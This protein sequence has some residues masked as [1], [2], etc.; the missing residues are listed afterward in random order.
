[1]LTEH[2]LHLVI[3]E[4]DIDTVGILGANRKLDSVKYR[5]IMSVNQLEKLRDVFIF[6]SNY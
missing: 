3:N 2:L 5:Q 1:M 6:S 4:P